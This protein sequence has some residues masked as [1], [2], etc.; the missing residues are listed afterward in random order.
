MTYR[1]IAGLFVLMIAAITSPAM[2]DT[3]PLNHTCTPPIKPAQ[4]NDNQQVAMFNDAVS[5]YKQ[6]I[7]TFTD[8]HNQAANMHRSAAD[9]AIGEWNDFV[10]DN[11]LN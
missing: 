7:T 6:C 8:E 9:D 3:F 4:F 5:A 10:N 1:R 2:A 11:N